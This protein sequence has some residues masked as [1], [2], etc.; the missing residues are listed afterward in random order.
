[1]THLARILADSLHNNKLRDNDYGITRFYYQVWEDG[2]IT[3]TQWDNNNRAVIKPGNKNK[4][5]IMP[6]I[7]PV[8]HSYA[9][10]S[11]YENALAIHEAIIGNYD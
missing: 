9:M 3:L 1:M 7:N 2:E 8:G 4:N 10:V 11:S 5:V 6:V